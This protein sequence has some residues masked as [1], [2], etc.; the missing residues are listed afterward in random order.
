MRVVVR[1]KNKEASDIKPLCLLT[2]ER[3][4]VVT[5]H[6]T[7]QELIEPNFIRWV[8]DH[9]VPRMRPGGSV[10]WLAPDGSAYIG[11]ALGS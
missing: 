8:R 5:I 2:G 7:Q 3:W 10:V 4:E 9:V 6:A 1:D 11:W